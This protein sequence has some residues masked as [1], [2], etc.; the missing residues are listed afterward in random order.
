MD[1]ALSE[2]QQLIIAT[3]KEFAE[4][5]VAPKAEEIDR[6]GRFASE[7]MKE[8][9]DLNFVNMYLPEEYGGSGTSY[10]TYTLVLEQIAK[11]CSSTGINLALQSLSGYPIFKFGT[12]EQRKKWLP[13]M[14]TCEAYGSFALTEPGAG[15]DPGSMSTRAVLDGDHYVIN[16]TK[17]FISNGPVAD[18]VTLFALTD[19]ENGAKGISAFVVE[20]G[21]P[22]FTVGKHEEKMGF[23]GAHTSELIFKDC[24]IPKENLLGKEGQGYKIALNTLDGGRI[25][26]AAVALG[27]AQAAL[28]E[29]ISYS[30]QRV[31]FKR[32]IA[33]NQ[34]IQFMIAEMATDI[35]AA[36]MMT[37]HA[38]YVKDTD[39]PVTLYSAMVKFFAPHVG[40][41]CADKAVQIHG[42][43]GYCKGFKVERLY[44]DAKLLEIAEGTSQAQLMVISGMLLR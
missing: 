28:E 37:Y 43:Y 22:G 26:V 8:M 15:T 18:I 35:H 34:G 44:R 27:I 4:K 41:T 20:K 33:S 23:N 39:E 29:S 36:R 11:A 9:A 31:Q 14:A 3:A 30:K 19:P 7:L 16:G 25:S 13:K 10:L 21:T 38:A 42:G 40:V 6:T 17:C 1:F 24:R 32:P 12:E 5:E 2:E